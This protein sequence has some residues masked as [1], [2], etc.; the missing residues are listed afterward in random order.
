MKERRNLWKAVVALTMVGA[1]CLAAV[2]CKTDADGPGGTGGTAEKDLA[3]TV[4][5]QASGPLVAGVELTA[6][7][8]GSDTAVDFRWSKDGGTIDATE[9]ADETGKKCK[10]TEAGS[11]TVTASAPGYKAKTSTVTVHPK[12]Y[13]TINGGGSGTSADPNPAEPEATVTLTPGDKFGYEFEG[14]EVVSPEDLE[15]KDN[16]FT[17]PDEVVEITATWTKNVYTVTFDSDGGSEVA[18]QQVEH[19]GYASVP[20]EPTKVGLTFAGWFLGEA[21]TA[22]AFTTTPITEGITLKAKWNATVTFDSDGGS[23]VVDQQVEYGKLAGV[24]N[25][26]PTK[27]GYAFGG[28]FLG[29]AE[30][31]FA[32][33]TPITENIT[34]KAK[35]GPIPGTVTISSTHIFTAQGLELAFDATVGPTGAPQDVTWSV[36]GNA[37][38]NFDGNILKV[39]PNAEPGKITVTVTVRGY[40]GIAVQRT[41]DILPGSGH[42]AGD[43]HTMGIKADGSL[44]AWG[45]N[46]SGQLGNG[47]SGSGTDKTTPKAIAVGQKWRPIVSDQ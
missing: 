43:G 12:G 34:L 40:S 27:T 2:A 16:T 1:V 26:A 22:F 10:T 23:P 31:A 37:K 42:S 8:D 5:I 9:A 28:W 3:G 13:I 46:N 18:P 30:T 36:T 20:P 29:N 7:Y 25:P 38:A 21:T 45:R 17:M 24:P 39:A 14:W 32:F 19:D 41:L 47:T 6:A 15:I 4:K 11:Y 44:W 33:S 35:W